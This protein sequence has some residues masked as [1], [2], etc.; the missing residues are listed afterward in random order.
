MR[1]GAIANNSFAS[2]LAPGGWRRPAALHLPLH[3]LHFGAHFGLEE[4]WR[5]V[6]AP[7]RRTSFSWPCDGHWT[8]YNR[9]RALNP[10]MGCREKKRQQKNLR[11]RRGQREVFALKMNFQLK[12]TAEHIKRE[13]EKDL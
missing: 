6:K 7:R 9:R 4:V 12:C 10:H 11:V 3:G 5:Q 13:M 1:C 8:A 2:A